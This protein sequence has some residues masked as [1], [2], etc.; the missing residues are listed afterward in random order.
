MYMCNNVQ[1]CVLSKIGLLTAEI[2]AFFQREAIQKFMNKL[3]TPIAIF[4]N[5]W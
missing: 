3:R 1:C 2:L 4:K 5:L